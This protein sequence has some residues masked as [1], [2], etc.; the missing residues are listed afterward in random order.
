MRKLKK[1]F[2]LFS[3]GISIIIL[4]LYGENGFTFDT[5]GINFIA[6]GLFIAAFA[7]LK[8]FRLSRVLVIAACGILGVYTLF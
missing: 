4:T 6:A 7:V 8:K 3:T 2:T 5:G 1:Y